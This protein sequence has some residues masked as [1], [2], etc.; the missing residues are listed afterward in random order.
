MILILF[1]VPYH[2]SRYFIHRPDTLLTFMSINLTDCIFP[3]LP[4]C[5][6]II[7]DHPLGNSTM[8]KK[9]QNRA[10]TW[11][12]T[13]PQTF[14]LQYAKGKAPKR[15][16]LSID[17]QWIGMA[18]HNVSLPDAYICNL[19]CKRLR[20][21]MQTFASWKPTAHRHQELPPTDHTWRSSE[22]PGEVHLKQDKRSKCP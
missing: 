17:F 18:F 1:F 14:G 21:R 8:L 13:A 10:K 5:S 2:S 22:T 6:R 11:P 20:P 15:H 19:T 7:Q 12:K 3:I 16:H 9:R 4:E